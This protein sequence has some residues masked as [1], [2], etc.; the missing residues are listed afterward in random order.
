MAIKTSS[1][2]VAAVIAVFLVASLS[3]CS[4]NNK[5]NTAQ[6]NTKENTNTTSKNVACTSTSGTHPVK[7][8]GWKTTLYSAPLSDKSINDNVPDNGVRSFS[9]TKLLDK[10]SPSSV[11]Y[12]IQ[13]ADGS[14][15][16]G[17]KSTIEVCD[18]HNKTNAL[19]AT[20]TANIDPLQGNELGRIIYLHSYIESTITPGEY[21][22]D[23]YLYTNGVWHLTDRMS[24]RLTK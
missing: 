7:L 14:Y 2:I 10:T 23:G 24:V 12:H 18:K 22:I 1:F 19:I 21:R 4:F 6:T 11:Y 3:A 20:S 5:S 8:P 9:I 16:T 13:K 15:A 17:A